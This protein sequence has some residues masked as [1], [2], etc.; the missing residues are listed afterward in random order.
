MS[1]EKPQGNGMPSW[2]KYHREIRNCKLCSW[3]LQKSTSNW[4]AHVE[5]IR[6]DVGSKQPR[7]EMPHVK[8]TSKNHGEG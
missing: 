8:A 1:K 7:V 5:I 2:R 4:V 6:G 3:K